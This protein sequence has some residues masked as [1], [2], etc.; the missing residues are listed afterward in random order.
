MNPPHTFP[1]VRRALLVLLAAFAAIAVSA[2]PAMAHAAVVQTVPFDTERLEPSDV[3]DAV[4]IVFNEPVDAPPGGIRVFN[5]DNE[6]VDVDGPVSAADGDPLVVGRLV[7]ELPVGSYLV[8]WRV[9]SADGHPIR[10]AY[11]FTVG[12]AAALSDGFIE[13]IFGAGE[14]P[15]RPASI[16]V[17]GLTYASVLLAA[18]ALLAISLGGAS[19]SDRV[20]ALVRRGAQAGIVLSLLTIPLQAMA[21]S[22][23]GLAA[24]TSGAQLGAVLSASV[25]VGAM[26]RIAALGGVLAL[27]GTAR[28]AA[29]VVA[30]LSFLIDG[31][32][33][34][35]DPA[36]LM[37][38]ADTVHLLAAA[39][40]FGGLI[41]L[42]LNLRARKLAD[43][44]IGGAAMVAGWSK[45]AMWT[46]VAV[47][48]AG[49]ALTFV[50]VRDP[51]ALFTTTYGQLLQVK[52]ILAAIVIA[53]GA[54]NHFK[55]VPAVERAIVSV[56]AGAS[57]AEVAPDGAAP[58]PA[59]VTVRTEAGWK[60]LGSTVRTEVVLLVAIMLVTGVLSS[61]RPASEAVGIGGIFDGTQAVAD[62]LDLQLLIDPNLAGRNSIH[63]YLLDATGRPYS[64]IEGLDM[65]LSLP[66]QDI[67][68]LERVPVVT[69]PGH[70]TLEGGELA[71]PG[72]WEITVNVRLDRFTQ[73][74]LTFT[75][76]VGAG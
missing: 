45:L 56:P 43:D 10:G 2:T 74:S 13:D 1:S 27:S 9:V 30:L 39:V 31:H 48:L 11:V 24:V 35:V 28:T 76:V 19:A 42:L 67:G 61:Q 33:R 36:W 29:G 22:G 57:D 32:T 41:V 21:V 44:P 50:L 26:V 58:V 46:V 70:W 20:T 73:Q 60:R 3:P 65:L 51:L 71:L 62:G 37:F 7:P 34:T 14:G 5:A 25:G 6:R 38:S 17:A 23:D 75:S 15:A 8:T 54:Y 68:P 63:L 16:V 72:T 53:V 52:L 49:S 47:S 55:L 69:G 40:W 12:D 4:T 64:D 59:P 66:A 18:G